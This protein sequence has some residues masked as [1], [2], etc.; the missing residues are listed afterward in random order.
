MDL[1]KAWEDNAEPFTLHEC[2][3]GFASVC[4]EAGV[5]AKR[6]QTWM[7]HS[8]I[9]TT[10]DLYGRLF[11]RSEADAVDRVGRLPGRGTPCGTTKSGAGRSR[12]VYGG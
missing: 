8:S 5:N 7:G 1:R 12:A 6:I 4:V 11:D 3:H 2:R 10:F 9:T